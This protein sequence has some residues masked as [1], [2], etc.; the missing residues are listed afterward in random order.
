MRT[1]LL[2]FGCHRP[3]HRQSLD[4][5]SLC[6]LRGTR[7]REGK[8]RTGH[9]SGRRPHPP[10]VRLYDR[11]ADGKPHPHAAFFR[12]EEHFKDLSWS[13]IPT[14]ESH[15]SVRT[16]SSCSLKRIVIVFGLSVTVC[17]D[18]MAFKTKFIRTCWS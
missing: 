18:S 17:M 4:R 15:I 5:N 11:F 2:G 14:P 10:F 13:A 8:D 16:I 1:K 6:S 3:L 7:N 9:R 12:R